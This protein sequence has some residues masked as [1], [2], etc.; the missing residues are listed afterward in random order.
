MKSAVLA[1]SGGVDSTLLLK[2]AQMAGI[3]SLAVTASSEII[4]LREISAAK[5]IAKELG[6]RHRVLEMGPLT[7]DFLSN[8]PGRC[9]SCK[10]ELFKNLANIAHL[11]EYEFVIDGSNREDLLDYRP[12]RKAASEYR[13]RSP[14]AEAGLSKNV[15]RKLSRDLGLQTWD[16]PS[17]PCLATRIPYGSR[18]TI[19]ALK[20]IEH[21]EDFLRSLGFRQVRVRDHGPVARIEI[22]D[23]EINLILELKK[24][25]KISTKL[26]SLGYKFISL[27]L[28][29]YRSGSMNRLLGDKRGLWTTL[30]T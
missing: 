16:R 29:G 23:D 20:R 17:S 5:D 10:T 4:P 27:D 1:F 22:G 13:V 24:R 2:A 3:R 25:K 9:F 8:T 30:D 21:S 6:A 11:E 18:I 26:R 15:I 28:E 14:L 19:E 12:G 7:E